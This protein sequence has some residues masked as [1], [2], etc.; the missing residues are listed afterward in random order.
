MILPRTFALLAGTAIGLSTGAAQA[1][2]AS[3]PTS[4]TIIQPTTLAS[5]LELDFGTIATTSAGG[6]VNLDVAGNNRMCASGLFCSGSFAFATLYVTGDVSTVQVTYN[7]AVTLTGPGT[8][9]DATILFPGGSGASV[10]LVNGEATIQFGADL[11]VGP[12]QTPGAYSGQFT[13]NVNYQ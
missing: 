11:V 12:N 9:M 3:S 8:P 10:N 5:L 13:V 4:A 7:P 2:S 6:T 1:D